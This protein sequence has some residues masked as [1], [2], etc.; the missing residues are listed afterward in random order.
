MA[1][2]DTVFPF[3][4]KGFHIMGQ[5]S[6]FRTIKVYTWKVLKNI[7]CVLLPSF[8]WRSLQHRRTNKRHI[9]GYKHNDH[10]TRYWNTN[11]ND[12]QQ[13]LNYLQQW[14]E[15]TTFDYYILKDGEDYKSV[16]KEWICIKGRLGI[17]LIL[18]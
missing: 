3:W 14:K 17:K 1:W 12:I 2:H 6:S 11:F 16:N 13:T 18:P 8:C 15:E 7:N 9:L 5:C 10:T 4:C